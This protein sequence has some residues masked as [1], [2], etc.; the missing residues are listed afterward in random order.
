MK[1]NIPLEKDVVFFK[2]DLWKD[3]RLLEVYETHQLK[4]LKRY[5]DFNIEIIREFDFLTFISKKK[6]SLKI[7]KIVSH[8]DDYIELEYITGIRV[9]NLLMILRNIFKKTN[10]KKVY[11]IAQLIKN[12]LISDMNEFQLISNTYINKTDFYYPYKQ[13]AINAIQIL[14]STV[15]LNINMDELEKDLTSLENIIQKTDS[16]IFRDATPKNAILRMQNFPISAS[17]R[18]KENIIMKYINDDFFSEQNIK[19]NVIQYDF[20]GFNMECSKYDDELVIEFHEALVWLQDSNYKA[21]LTNEELSVLLFRLIRLAL[22]KLAYK[23][24]HINAYNIRFKLDSELIY[25]HEMKSIINTLQ[26][27]N[28]IKG[29]GL[30][31]FTNSMINLYDYTPTVDYFEKYLLSNNRQYYTDIFPH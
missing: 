29:D 11:K 21:R 24:L 27:I 23:Q 30:L 28:Y 14:L 17:I 5:S 9:F 22:R 16:S 12:K 8:N 6:K 15:E 10:D 25:L 13:K 4:T 2:K 31:K 26:K 3:I 18:E 1:I 20:S 19:Q 7:P